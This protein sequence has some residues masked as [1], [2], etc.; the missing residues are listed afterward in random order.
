MVGIGKRPVQEDAGLRNASSKAM[1]SRILHVGL[2]GRP[3]RISP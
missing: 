2:V 1:Q 3:R